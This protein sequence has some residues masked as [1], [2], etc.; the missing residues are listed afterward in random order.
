L[1]QQNSKKKQSLVTHG[2]KIKLKV[3]DLVVEYESMNQ[4]TQGVLLG[5]KTKGKKSL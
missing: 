5:E 1:K 3:T 4:W 2:S